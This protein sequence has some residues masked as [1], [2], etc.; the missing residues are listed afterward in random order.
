MTCDNINPQF[1]FS[2][3]LADFPEPQYLSPEVFVIKVIIQ[4]LHLGQR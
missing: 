1:S 4:V 2:A 3:H